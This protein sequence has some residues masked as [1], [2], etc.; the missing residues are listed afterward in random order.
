MLGGL[1]FIVVVGV[2]G[3]NQH[4]GSIEHNTRR[5]AEALSAIVDKF[6]D[7][8]DHDQ[9]MQ[10]VDDVSCFLSDVKGG[11]YPN[12]RRDTWY[13]KKADFARWEHTQIMSGAD[14]S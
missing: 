4:L 9:I 13:P 14:Q 10:V 1:F 11:Q 6:V 2:W 12:M 5:S 8:R 3:I 7:T